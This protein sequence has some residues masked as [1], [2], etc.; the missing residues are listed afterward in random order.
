MR[1]VDF[2][3]VRAELTLQGPDNGDRESLQKQ[4]KSLRRENEIRFRDVDFNRSS[5]DVISD[6]H[7]VC[8]PSRFEGFGL[9]AIVERS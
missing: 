3:L 9:A 5:S 7:V 8:L 4:V 6:H 1:G 2:L